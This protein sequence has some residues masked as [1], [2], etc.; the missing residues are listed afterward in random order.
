M[1]RYEDIVYLLC[2]D[3]ILSFEGDS[4]YGVGEP[5]EG[6][7]VAINCNDTFAYASADAEDIPIG[8]EHEVR[9]IYDKYGHAGVIAW[10]SKERGIEPLPAFLKL[11]S[12]GK[13]KL[14]RKELESK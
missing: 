2:N 8:R 5:F 9:S 7:I 11:L 3:V 4:F 6:L 12:A 13:Y 14:A 1:N 10:C